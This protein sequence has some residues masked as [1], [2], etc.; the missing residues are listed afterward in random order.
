M[1]AAERRPAVVRWPAVRP[2]VS[3]LTAVALVSGC[4][5]T[6]RGDR[7]NRPTTPAL[8]ASDSLRQDFNDARVGSVP[9]GWTADASGPGA[10]AVAAFPDPV[11]RSLRV[12]KTAND[13]QVT[14]AT[15]FSGLAGVVQVEARIRVER[16]S[17]RLDL[18]DISGSDERAAASIAIRD[19]QFTEVASGRKLLPATALRWYSLRVVLRTDSHRF[20]LVI[21][22]QKVLADAP[23]PKPAKDVGR[24]TAGIGKGYTGTLYLDSVA[25]YRVVAPSVDYAV[26]D[27]YNDTPIGAE[28]AGY[29]VIAGGGQV[30]VVATP[31][32]ED[33]GL[34]V[35]KPKTAGDT[36]AT[37]SF[38]RQTGTVTVQA[39]VRTDEAAGSK[40][41][42]NVQSSTGKTAC[43][44]RF[45]NGWLFYDTDSGTYQLTPVSAG[46]W[47]T[48]R[49]I[50]DVTGQRAELFIDGR[51]FAPSVPG[52]QV[53]PRW[54]FSDLRAT[55]VGRVMFG[56]LAGQ[57][58]TVRVDNLMVFSNPVARP[59]G[60]V[61]DVRKDPYGAA[62]DGVTD[63]TGA[64]QRAVDVVPAGGS[65]LLS[66][67]VFRSGT[68]KLKSDM[69]LW[70]DRDAVLL[71]DTDD[72]A[73]PI[74]DA[75]SV[76]TPSFGGSGSRRALLLSVNANNVSI[77][78]GGTI[79]G[80]GGKPEWA[81][82]ST[83][84]GGTVRPTMMFLTRGHNISVRNVHVR[85]AASWAIVPAEDDG[86]LIADVD[87]DS[88]LYA[89]RDGIDVVD[90]KAVLIERVNVWS[91]DDAICF[92][93]FARG[94]DGAV[95]RL[96]TVGHSE[97]ANG[98]KFGTESLG[99]FRNVLVEDVLVK[100]VD[101]AAITVVAV[102]GATVSSLTFRRITIDHALRVFF[103]LLG[104]RNGAAKAP[105]WVSSV[106]FEDISGSNLTEPA[107][108]SGQRLDGTTYRLYDILVSNV[109][110]VVSGGAQTIP[111]GPAEYPGN[112]PESTF[113]SR[114]SEPPAYG[115]FFRYVDGLTMRASSAV[116]Q[117]PDVRPV[118]ALADVLNANVG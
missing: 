109:H 41:A 40:V 81:F 14:A 111:D 38:S 31:S 36:T 47:Y 27:Q 52:Q 71:G 87:I 1:V 39:N 89:N 85:D 86:V 66:G 29:E 2:L 50:L 42:V 101:K 100:H 96:S 55:N 82:D 73:Y 12:T 8:A 97:R 72:S 16:T 103:V 79:D 19:G 98:V 21:D 45:D 7:G 22:G 57:T 23:F 17:G 44:I 78:G 90:S 117:S 76:G 15:R 92:K 54:T 9:A 67:G 115:W 114:G 43:A 46:E 65:V 63:D 53:A 34:Q 84:G 88:N 112:Y 49:L 70:I 118:K 80:N 60:T 6:G 74:F 99:A 113:L 94:V 35:A 77:D 18:L 51:R 83:N 104:M 68:I 58:G 4:T 91:D 30:S 95:V 108:V 93:S 116:T 64:I 32:N 25:I 106:H 11:D 48:I 105:A 13:G 10:V 110:E 75:A 56:V 28:P 26:L 59:P 107:A 102:D 20:D 3:V 61:I 69:T 62:G 5:A 37:R 33:R 24:V